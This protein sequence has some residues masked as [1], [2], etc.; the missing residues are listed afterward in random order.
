LSSTIMTDINVWWHP[1]WS[2]NI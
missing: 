2:C 1:T